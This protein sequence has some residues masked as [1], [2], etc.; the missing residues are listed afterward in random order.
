MSKRN[1]DKR[2]TR[3]THPIPDSEPNTRGESLADELLRSGLPAFIDQYGVAEWCPTPD[4]S[5]PPEMVV[6]HADVNI[7]NVPMTVYMRFKSAG[8]VDRLIGMLT[9]HRLSVWPEV[10]Q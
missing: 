8:E 2:R 6:L 1:R 10:P 9:R 4:G 3:D 7:A 5:G